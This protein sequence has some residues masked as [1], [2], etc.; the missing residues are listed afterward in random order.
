MA[1]TQPATD[2]HVALVAYAARHVPAILAGSADWR[3]LAA[4]G[5]P[6][7]R[8]RSEAELQRKISSQ[9]GPGLAPEYNFVLETGGRLVGE[10]SVHSIDYRNRVGQIGVCI[11]YDDDR[12]R[13]YALDGLHDLTAWA[14]GNLGLQRLEAWIMSDNAPSRALFTRLSFTYEGTLR[15][16][17]LAACLRRDVE[18]WALLT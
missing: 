8:P 3:A 5:A 13:G 2:N 15:Q 14:T 9:S 18:I 6:Y 4:T 10:C 11:W 7:W 12:R 1:T 16:R 17:Y